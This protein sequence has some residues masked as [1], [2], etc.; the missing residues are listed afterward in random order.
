[1][2]CLGILL[3]KNLHDKNEVTYKSWCSGKENL[4]EA[5]FLHGKVSYSSYANCK[6]YVSRKR[7]EDVMM[8][9]IDMI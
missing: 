8:Y 6:M 2:C 4:Y 9:D 5:Y 1:M 3:S 7:T